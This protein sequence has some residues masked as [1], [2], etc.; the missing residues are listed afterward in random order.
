MNGATPLVIEAAEAALPVAP[1]PPGG[2]RGVLSRP[3]PIIAAS[4]EAAAGAEGATAPGAGEAAPRLC[5]VS[6]VPKRKQVSQV[7]KIPP[8]FLPE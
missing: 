5:L 6:Q 8:K 4:G 1:G 3:L 7:P 2:K